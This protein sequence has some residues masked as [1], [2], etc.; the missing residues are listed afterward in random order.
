VARVLR[1]QPART[2]LPCTQILLLRRQHTLCTRVQPSVRLT[3]AEPMATLVAL[4]ASLDDC[5]KQQED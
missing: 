3:P 4:P 5:V 1:T 2:Q